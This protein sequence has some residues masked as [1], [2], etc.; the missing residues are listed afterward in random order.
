MIG[1]GVVLYA[2][3]LYSSPDRRPSQSPS[4]LDV[5]ARAGETE[6]REPFLEGREN[7]ETVEMRDQRKGDS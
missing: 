5:E 4:H 3:Y 6:E 1:T 7:G 2:T